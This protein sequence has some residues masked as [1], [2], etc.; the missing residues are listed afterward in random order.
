MLATAVALG[1]SAF[2][3]LLVLLLRLRLKSSLPGTPIPKLELAAPG[4]IAL[5][6][7]L[8]PLVG[9]RE[10]LRC[11][12]ERPAGV[13]L[14]LILFP[15]P[16]LLMLLRSPAVDL[17]GENDPSSAVTLLLVDAGLLPDKLIV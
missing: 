12:A 4:E 8:E 11:S 7:L 2:Q 17:L 5:V 14:W 15:P 13:I 3:L 16:L 6:L 10:G 9:L 1:G